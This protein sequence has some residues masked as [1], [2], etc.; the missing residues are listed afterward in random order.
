VLRQL[1][2]VT[3]PGCSLPRH[4]GTLSTELIT[5]ASQSTSS[6]ALSRSQQRRT[7]KRNLMKM[8]LALV[9]RSSVNTTSLSGA[10]EMASV[11]K[12][13]AKSLPMLRSLFVSSLWHSLSV[14]TNA[15]SNALLQAQAAA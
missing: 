5:L 13:C 2:Q 10:H 12:R 1:L 6:C 3:T 14:P 7:W 9:V 4:F 11:P 8:R 15:S